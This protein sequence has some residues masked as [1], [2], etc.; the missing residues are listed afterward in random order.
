MAQLTKF[1]LEFWNKFDY[2]NNNLYCKEREKIN[3]IKKAQNV[4][5]NWIYIFNGRPNYTLSISV[6]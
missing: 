2:Y 1:K 4:A 6:H 3:Q 5:K